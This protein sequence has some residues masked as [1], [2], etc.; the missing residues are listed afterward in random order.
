AANILTHESQF[1]LANASNIVAAACYLAATALVYHL[2]KPVD[3]DV[4]LLAA[5]FSV[6]ACAVSGIGFLLRLAPLAVLTRA[7]DGFSPEQIQT[8]AL[9]F[10]R[11][12]ATAFSVSHVFFGLHC[13]LVGVLI[14]RSVFLPRAIGVLMVGAGLGWLT[15]SF[16]NLVL[17]SFGRVL[18]PFIILPGAIGELTLALW[19][20]F[21]GVN[22]Q[23]WR[24][25]ANV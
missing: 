25:Q 22:L 8:L 24:E 11:L 15:M 5:F 4:S 2:L 9:T 7:L 17:P 19:L 21:A 16:S 10:L 23:R 3:R 1:R 20:L 6:T 12:N 13:L 14:L 18:Y